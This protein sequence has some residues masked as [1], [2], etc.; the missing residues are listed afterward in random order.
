MCT[1]YVKIGSKNR[2]Y[3]LSSFLTLQVIVLWGFFLLKPNTTKRIKP[4][5]FILLI[6]CIEPNGCYYASCA[7]E[8]YCC[9][10]HVP[11]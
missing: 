8:L 5:M 4:I 1:L 6:L 10:K 11:H 7:P 3:H 2:Y 9:E